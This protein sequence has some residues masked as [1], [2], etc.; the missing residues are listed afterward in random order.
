MRAWVRDFDNVLRVVVQ[1]DAS[2]VMEAVASVA[3]AAKHTELMFRAMY[4]GD[5]IREALYG[6]PGGRNESNRVAGR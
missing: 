6:T 3:A 4:E 5:E 1:F 2:Q